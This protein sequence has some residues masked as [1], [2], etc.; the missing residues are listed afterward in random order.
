MTRMIN[1]LSLERAKMNASTTDLLI[2]SGVLNF[3]DKVFPSLKELRYYLHKNPMTSKDSILFQ[4]LIQF[5]R[6]KLD[7]G[8]SSSIS[9]RKAITSLT[10]LFFKK[11]SKSDLRRQ[12][13]KIQE[14][15]AELMKSMVL[16]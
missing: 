1:L 11:V 13:K 3:K 4:L 16:E 14:V 6:S 15:G 8:Q 7:L 12:S 2:E 9:N 5:Y 10:I